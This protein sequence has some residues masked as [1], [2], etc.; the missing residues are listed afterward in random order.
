MEVNVGLENAERRRGK[1]GTMF[2]DG[3]KGNNQMN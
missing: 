2:V 1:N 3:G